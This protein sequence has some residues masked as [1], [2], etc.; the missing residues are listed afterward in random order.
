MNRARNDS[1]NFLE[2]DQLVNSLLNGT[3]T[4][5]EH[6][7]LQMLLRDHPRMQQEYLALIDLHLA[8]KSHVSLRTPRLER[9][10]AVVRPV[11]KKRGSAPRFRSWGSALCAVALL[12]LVVGFLLQNQF[13]SGEWHEPSIGATHNSENQS[14]LPVI[15]DAPAASLKQ[16]AGAELMKEFVPE[17]G[18]V[19]QSGHEYTLVKG[20][21]GLEFSCGAEV[22]IQAPAIFIVKSPKRLDL[23]IGT[24]SVFAPPTASGFEVIT[25]QN[26]IIDLGTRFSVAVNDFGASE[27]QVVE[28]MAEVQ[29]PE[30]PEVISTLTTGRAVRSA[31]DRKEL[32]DIPFTGSDYRHG[33]QDRV[34]SYVATRDPGQEG[35]RDLLSVTVQRNGQPIQYSVNEL[36]GIEVIHFRSGGSPNN[37]ASD[38]D[39]PENLSELLT[40][41]HALNTGLINFD[42]NRKTL[43]PR[44]S[45]FSQFN[46]R[47]GLAVRF[48]EPVKNHAGPDIVLFEV[49]SVAYPLEGDHF[50]VSP[51]EDG[52]GLNSHVIKQFDITLHSADA[53]KVAPFRV[54]RFPKPLQSLKNMTDRPATRGGA[55]TLPFYALAVGIDLS[56]LG[57]AP[58]AEVPGIFLE[59][60]STE[61]HHI[62][63][64]VFIGGLPPLQ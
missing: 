53:Q 62:I 36:I 33:L 64:P 26:R 16:M 9:V 20:Q 48:R 30:S 1:S 58:G 57:Y 3:I 5:V 50:R 38:R 17:V 59:D 25:P 22:I 60:A 13:T 11:K 43:H 21:L 28:G 27:I 63:D 2:L 61:T 8:L 32:Q 51:I 44:E 42:G 52:P 34:I 37:A 40:K 55:M 18:A 24:C 49:Q 14:A 41:D 10:D 19:L 35:V 7:R 4:P 56:D 15:Q 45:N 54:Y 31:Q 29:F 12:G 46:D 23:K 6:D 39:L 47:A